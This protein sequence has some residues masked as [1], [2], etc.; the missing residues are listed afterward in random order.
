MLKGFRDFILRG[1]V[2]DLAVGVIIGGAFGTV[3]TSLVKDVFTPFIGNLV[4]KPDFS[5]IAVQPC[6]GWQLPQRSHRIS[7]G[8]SHGLLF[9]RGP[10]QRA[11][12]SLQEART[13]C[14]A[15]DKSMS[16]MPER[17]P[18]RG[19]TLRTLRTAGGIKVG[20]R[21]DN[22]HR[23]TS[24]Q[25]FLLVVPY[26]LFPTPLSLIN[27]APAAAA[28]MR[29]THERQQ[30]HTG[31]HRQR[32]AGWNVP[33]QLARQQRADRRQPQKACRIDAH[34][35]AAHLVRRQVLDRHVEGRD[36]QDSAEALEK[37]EAL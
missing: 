24:H 20:S 18:D 5:A 12:G 33:R 36:H 11:D 14:A 32:M 28:R 30:C 31:H 10:G 6:H 29:R 15:G 4:G 16:G 8:C 3:V 23:L 1:N 17:Y 19:E 7:D 25:C 2:L 22:R 34:H 21:E 27:P 37:C 9:Y 26:S 13:R 35:A